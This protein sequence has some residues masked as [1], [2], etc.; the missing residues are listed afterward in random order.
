MNLKRTNR[1]DD[2]DHQ[3]NTANRVGRVRG[4][5]RELR[6]SIGVFSH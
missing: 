3:Q 1:L 4:I 2:R 5:V 6:L